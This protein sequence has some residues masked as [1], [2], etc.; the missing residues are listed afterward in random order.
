[1]R[2]NASRRAINLN[3]PRC[4]EHRALAARVYLALSAMQGFSGV[5]AYVCSGLSIR[6]HENKFPYFVAGFIAGTFLFV[7]SLLSCRVYNKNPFFTSSEVARR[8]V[9]CA[10]SWH[11][12][13]SF[14][15]L[16][17]C[18]FSLATLW[19]YGLCVMDDDVCSYEN[20]IRFN[21]VLAGLA[22]TFCC[23]GVVSSVFGISLICFFG[24]AFGLVHIPG[25]GSTLRFSGSLG[26]S[27]DFIPHQ[28]D[29]FWPQTDGQFRHNSASDRLFNIGFEPMFPPPYCAWDASVSV[30]NDRVAESYSYYGPPKYD[31][32]GFS[33][34]T[35]EAAV[36]PVDQP[37]PYTHP[38]EAPAD[39]STHL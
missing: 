27:R 20:N 21:R 18:L 30:I 22:F 1:M 39:T 23:A 16:F 24:K 7:S 14:Y 33:A 35:Y 2:E 17:V 36:L 13:L 19:I 6:L 28:N 26:P 3:D 8:E 15:M 5:G 31:D 32:I 34:N 29:A 12:T 9:L 4:E 11:R 38:A 37:P 10:V 25:R